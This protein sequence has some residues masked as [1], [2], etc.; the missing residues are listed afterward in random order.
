MTATTTRQVVASERSSNF[1]SLLAKWKQMESSSTMN[2]RTSLISLTMRVS[3]R[4]GPSPCASSVHEQPQHNSNNSGNNV[5][6]T[7]K[8]PWSTSTSTTSKACSTTAISKNNAS[9]NNKNKTNDNN[10]VLKKSIRLFRSK[11]FET[12]MSTATTLESCLDHS[13]MSDTCNTEED[14]DELRLK[15]QL[16]IDPVHLITSKE[17]KAH[18]LDHSFE[19]YYTLGN[20]VGTIHLYDVKTCQT[21]KD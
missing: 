5:P 10:H 15:Q 13:D 1:G 6:V 11:R 2:D 8:K 4:V 12:S 17:R 18:I 21:N 16:E 7:V 20:E 9:N 14:G 19:D 3:R